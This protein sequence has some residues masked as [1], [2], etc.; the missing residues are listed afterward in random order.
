MGSV[1]AN[2]LNSTKPSS[3]KPQDSLTRA[4]QDNP[5]YGLEELRDYALQ[6]V[7]QDD[8]QSLPFEIQSL[9]L[10]GGSGNRGA[11][12]DMPPLE[13]FGLATQDYSPNTLNNIAINSHHAMLE[14]QHAISPNFP[15]AATG[16]AQ[17]SALLSNFSGDR[18]IHTTE[19]LIENIR[20]GRIQPA[21]LV[22]A[23]AY[24]ARAIHENGKVNSDMAGHIFVKAFGPLQAKWTADGDQVMEQM[25][26]RGMPVSGSY[27]ASQEVIYGEDYFNSDH[28][29][30]SWERAVTGFFGVV[31][32]VSDVGLAFGAARG[33]GGVARGITDYNIVRGTMTGSMRVNGTAGA[34]NARLVPKHGP[35]IPAGLTN[36]QVKNLLKTA[37]R[38]YIRMKNTGNPSTI[39]GVLFDP[40]TR[41]TYFGYSGEIMQIDASVLGRLPSREAF[42]ERFGESQR[43]WG[44]RGEC[45]E[46]R[47]VTRAISDGVPATEIDRLQVYAVH[48]INEDLEAIGLCSVCQLTFPYNKMVK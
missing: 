19:W 30:S 6:A 26:Y 43:S 33:I 2:T 18:R 48:W 28:K 39:Y 17:I 20:I 36:R 47:G 29:L 31:G 14:L 27:I 8:F 1:A 12:A 38:S 16:V 7:L 13:L 24:I 32:V 37:L 23:G 15:G 44:W 34:I 35:I 46:C 40:L 9:S 42:V 4:C 25:F 41:K 5:I 45:F 3:L 21:D 11:L 10:E 22:L